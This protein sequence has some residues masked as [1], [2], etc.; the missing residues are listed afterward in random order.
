MANRTKADED[1]RVRRVTVL[2]SAREYE[3]LEEFAALHTE[4]NVSHLVRMALRYFYSRRALVDV[5]TAYE[6]ETNN[7]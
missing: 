3:E 7:G 5:T 2:M 6:V 4:G 1:V